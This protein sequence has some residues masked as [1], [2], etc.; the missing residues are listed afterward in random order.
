M[1]FNFTGNVA[2]NL[3]NNENFLYKTVLLVILFNRMCTNVYK[4]L[5][6]MTVIKLFT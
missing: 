4:I 6:F 1:T 5:I 2:Q 3:R